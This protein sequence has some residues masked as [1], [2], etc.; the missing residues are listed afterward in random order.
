MNEKYIYLEWKDPAS[1]DEWTYAEDLEIGCP[2][3][4]SLGI[5]VTENKETI[6]VALNRDTE[7]DAYSC[8][9]Q[10]PKNVILKRK[11]IKI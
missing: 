7:S 11:Y 10:I 6:V 3:I 1:I 9:M 5:L 2:V 4:K 8:I